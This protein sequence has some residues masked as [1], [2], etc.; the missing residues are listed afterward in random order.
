M[1]ERVYIFIYNR[2][3]RYSLYLLSLTQSVLLNNYV[4]TDTLRRDLIIDF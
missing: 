2:R 3:L 1:C 4:T